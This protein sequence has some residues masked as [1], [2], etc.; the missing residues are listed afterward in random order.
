MWQSIKGFKNALKLIVSSILVAFIGN[1]KMAKRINFQHA[2]VNHA[3]AVVATHSPLV[4]PWF[5]PT[6][7]VTPSLINP[8]AILSLNQE[9]QEV[10]FS[11]THLQFIDSKY[12]E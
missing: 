9:V 10:A 1:Q 2:S 6:T 3:L 12:E 8:L 4:A 5:P 7:R 11:N